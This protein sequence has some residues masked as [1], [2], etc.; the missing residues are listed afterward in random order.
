MQLYTFP[1][2]VIWDSCC[3]SAHFSTGY[4][5]KSFWEE[6]FCNLLFNILCVV[7]VGCHH[8]SQATLVSPFVFI[9]CYAN[10]NKLFVPSKQ[11]ETFKWSK[12]K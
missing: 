2:N 1:S 12:R 10:L 5:A 7:S 11:K 4:I 8:K 6:K 3:R 9:N